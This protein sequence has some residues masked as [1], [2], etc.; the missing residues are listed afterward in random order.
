MENTV[1]NAASHTVTDAVTDTVSDGVSDGERPLGVTGAQNQNQNQTLLTV[2]GSSSM[3]EQSIHRYRS[4][5]PHRD[6]WM[7]RS[8]ARF[9]GRP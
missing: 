1:S 3:A 8:A 6:A 4:R 9:E 5:G 2:V 7:G